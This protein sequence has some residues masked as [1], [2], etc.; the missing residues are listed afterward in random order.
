VLGAL[1]VCHC[2]LVIRL[3]NDDVKEAFKDVI[4]RWQLCT[5]NMTSLTTDNASNNKKAFSNCYTRITCFEHNLDLAV[6]KEL[7]VD[8]SNA[9]S[10]LRR[11]VAAFNRSTKSK[12]E[13]LAMQ[14]ERDLP[15]H[16]PIHDEPTRWG[17]TYDMIDRFLE[18][19]SA[20]C[21]V[22]ARDRQSWQ[23]MPTDADIIVSETSGYATWFTTGGAIRIGHYDV[24]DDV[25]TWKL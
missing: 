25:I 15:L 22:L 13:L 3:M 14:T 20:M 24:I 16:S 5:D 19:Q 1:V 7:A 11:V 18:Q 8:E 2:T 4:E 9:L 12:R 6:K 17:S 23:I 10:R 21:A